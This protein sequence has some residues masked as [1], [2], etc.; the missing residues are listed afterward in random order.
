MDTNAVEHM[1]TINEDSVLSETM[2]NSELDKD[3]SLSPSCEPN[4][5]SGQG[6]EEQTEAAAPST[7]E[8]ETT[9]RDQDTAESP[10]PDAPGGT[11]TAENSPEADPSQMSV[12]F[13]R[14]KY[15][16]ISAISR[17]SPPTEQVPPSPIES[18]LTHNSNPYL[19]S[20]SGCL[21]V[22][23]DTPHVDDSPANPETKESPSVN[24]HSND[25]CGDLALS[26]TSATP[27]TSDVDVPPKENPVEST[28]E[29]SADHPSPEEIAK[30]EEKSKII[31]REVIKEI[32][33]VEQVYNSNLWYFSL[34]SLWSS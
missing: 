32:C 13:R 17:S 11:D 12:Q 33:N 23:L 6:N 24:A 34:S 28:K 10:T 4:D 1:S 25:Q 26:E 20:E 14:T 2:D 22:T 31:R 29:D 16:S 8:E 3:S 19:R 18:Y 21:S 9:L 30:R 15:H 27:P 5:Q 7:H